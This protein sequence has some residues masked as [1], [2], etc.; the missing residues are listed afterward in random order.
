MNCAIHCIDFI[1]TLPICIIGK[2]GTVCLIFCL[3]DFTIFHPSS[4]SVI[5]CDVI[6]KCWLYLIQGSPELAVIVCS[7]LCKVA[8]KGEFEDYCNAPGH[9]VSQIVGRYNDGCRTSGHTFAMHISS[10]K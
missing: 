8:C 9:M 2:E 6:P 4:T 3:L 1:L 7:V 10:T 5:K